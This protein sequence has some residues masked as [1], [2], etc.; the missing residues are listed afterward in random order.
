MD[1]QLIADLI[2][3]HPEGIGMEGLMHAFGDQTT[4]R[5]MQRR[6]AELLARGRIRT[7]G[8][9][10]ALKYLPA[11]AMLRPVS[12]LDTTGAGFRAPPLES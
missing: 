10:R 1:P 8:R 7:H 9:S 5:T 2:D 4:R 11:P 3:L 6:L 12:A